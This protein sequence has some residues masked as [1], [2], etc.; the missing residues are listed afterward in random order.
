M[1]TGITGSD[2]STSTSQSLTHQ[3]CPTQHQADRFIDLVERCTSHGMP[4]NEQHI[5]SRSYLVPF[6]P[7]PHRFT[8]PP[9][10]PVP[11][12]RLSNSAPDG[13]AKS[14]VLQAIWQRRHHQKRMD[15]G[16]PL[17][18]DTLKV[19]IRSQSMLSTHEIIGSWLAG[20]GPKD[21]TITQ[22]GCGDL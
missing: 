16:T 15:L 22:S 11:G 20:Q 3:P 13:K 6:H 4:G 2:P 12:Y 8:H 10:Y 19:G 18:S 9:L 21:W 17:V 14:A 5:P 1:S 7:H